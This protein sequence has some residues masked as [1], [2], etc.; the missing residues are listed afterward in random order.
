MRR[1]HA[2]GTGAKRGTYATCG[3]YRPASACPTAALRLLP[4]GR[5]AFRRLPPVGVVGGRRREAAR[6]HQEDAEEDPEEAP[7]RRGGSIKYHNC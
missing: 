7:E 2:G 4:A 6:R 5:A 3:R 1:A